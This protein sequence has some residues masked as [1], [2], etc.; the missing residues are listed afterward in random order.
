MI[1]VDFDGIGGTRAFGPQRQARNWRPSRFRQPQ[2][3][4]SPSLVPPVLAVGHFHLYVRLMN[5]SLPALA[6]TLLGEL[7]R[8]GF[9]KGASATID[10][11]TVSMNTTM[12]ATRSKENAIAAI[13]N[14]SPSFPTE[15]AGLLES[16]LKLP[17]GAAFW[18]VTLVF[19]TE[20]TAL[21]VGQHEDRIKGD[22]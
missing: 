6:E 17:T 21:R 4:Q 5:P 11:K 7:T 20:A 18:V 2:V 15:C 8:G 16:S 14:G 9:V 12:E 22:S 3:Y 13:R 19:D 10:G 1:Q